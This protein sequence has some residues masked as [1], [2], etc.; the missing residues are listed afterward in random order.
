MT[1]NTKS[2]PRVRLTILP[3]TRKLPSGKKGINCLLWGKRWSTKVAWEK[4]MQ[5]KY[6]VMLCIKDARREAKKSDHPL[7][8]AI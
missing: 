3:H 8:P 6:R 4:K 1:Y 2:A 7:C 5:F